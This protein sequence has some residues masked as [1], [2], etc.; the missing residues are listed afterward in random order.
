[1]LKH[2]NQTY[3]LT[4][5]LFLHYLAKVNVKLYSFTGEG[6]SND[7]G[8]VESRVTLAIFSDT[9]EMR[10][11]LLYGDIQSVVDFSVIPKCTTL[12]DPDWLFRVKFCFQAGLAG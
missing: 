12:N 9:I 4:L 5:N 8:V 2:R 11:A 3:H 10:P 7:S 1:M 6:A